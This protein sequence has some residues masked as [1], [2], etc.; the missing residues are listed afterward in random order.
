MICQLWFVNRVVSLTGYSNWHFRGPFYNCLRVKTVRQ[1]LPLPMVL[2]GRLH[3][4]TSLCHC[5]DRLFI[6][7]VSHKNVRRARESERGGGGGS[8][9]NETKF[10]CWFFEARAKREY[11]GKRGSMWKFRASQKLLLSSFTWVIES[12]FDLCFGFSRES[13]K[14]IRQVAVVRRGTV[15]QL[16]WL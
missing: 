15:W 9:Q 10:C 16:L 12:L 11:E 14:G 1:M 5:S 6:Y 3:R 8:R 2:S 7:S 13:G 4:V